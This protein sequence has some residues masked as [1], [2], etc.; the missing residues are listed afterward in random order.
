[1]LHD[2]AYALLRHSCDETL[3]LRSQSVV[4]VVVVVEQVASAYLGT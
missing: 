2:H 4:E 3:V 1:L